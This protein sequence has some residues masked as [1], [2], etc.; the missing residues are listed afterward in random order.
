MKRTSPG[1]S[2]PGRLRSDLSARPL[3]S[4]NPRAPSRSEVLRGAPPLGLGLVAALL[5]L[6]PVGLAP[7]HGQGTPG[8]AAAVST[9]VDLRP[10][11]T[12]DDRLEVD[13]R[14]DLVLA[15]RVVCEAAKVDHTGEQTQVI[16]RRYK[17]QLVAVKDGKVA[18]VERRF[19][20]AWD[21]SREPGASTLDREPSPLHQRKIVVGLDAEGKRRV[22]PA[23]DPPIPESALEDEL[24]T[25]RWEAALPPE[26]VGPGATWKVEGAALKRALGNGL[27]EAPEGSITCRFVEVRKVVL[28]EGLPERPYAVIKVVADARGVQGDEADAPRFST[29]LEGELLFDLQARKLARVSLAGEARLR[30]TRRDGDAVMEID[31]KGPLTIEKR[32]WFPERPPARRPGAAT[33][34]PAGT[35][36][37]GLP[38]PRPG[39]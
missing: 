5:L 18:T 22:R 8:D 34:P 14:M 3:T 28:D 13:A 7:A 30:Q 11:Y 33:E 19:L 35:E 20:E 15:I 12:L 21:G 17:D 23:D 16:V 39:R 1:A 9:L 10:H 2:L 29:K 4:T 24:H 32:T 36:P 25:E 38:P 37:P 26:P 31:G 27:G 6:L